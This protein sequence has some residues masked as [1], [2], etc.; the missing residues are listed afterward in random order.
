MNSLL[1][2][3][4]FD[5]ISDRFEIQWILRWI[6]F[7]RSAN[8]WHGTV[9]VLTLVSFDSKISRRLWSFRFELTGTASNRCRELSSSLFCRDLSS[10]CTFSFLLEFWSRNFGKNLERES[11]T[12]NQVFQKTFSIYFHGPLCNTLQRMKLQCSRIVL[13]R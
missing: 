6:L 1:K 12:L 2:N 3:T 11:R 7:T 8:G 13:R 9:T 5:I 4:P 10:S